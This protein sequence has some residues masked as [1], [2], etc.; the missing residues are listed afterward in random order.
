MSLVI[1]LGS[2]AFSVVPP[3]ACVVLASYLLVD[4]TVLYV[5][6]AVDFV[7]QLIGWAHVVSPQFKTPC[8][9]HSNPVTGTATLYPGTY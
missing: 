6:I 3:V 8:V 7:L 1:G 2:Y 4:P 5:L 9:A